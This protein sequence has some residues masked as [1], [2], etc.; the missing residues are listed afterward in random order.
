MQSW[1]GEWVEDG[2]LKGE[3]IIFA[4][5]KFIHQQMYSLL[6]LKKLQIYV[7]NHF[8]LLLHVSA[9]DHYQ[10]AFTRA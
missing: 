8:D 5:I 7:K 10:G 1:D 4:F 9:Y 6:N 2:K 3:N